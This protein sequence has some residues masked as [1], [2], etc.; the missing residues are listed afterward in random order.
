MTLFRPR[1]WYTYCAEEV[2]TG[3]S[4]QSLLHFG[5]LMCYLCAHTELSETLHLAS[6]D[7]KEAS[8]SDSDQG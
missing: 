4:M 5:T 7:P 2:N 3:S 8:C 6:K 1:L